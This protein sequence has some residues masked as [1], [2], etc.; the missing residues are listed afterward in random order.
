MTAK[1]IGALGLAQGDCEEGVGKRARRYPRQG[2]RHD[3]RMQPV[4]II[5]VCPEF[6]KTGSMLSRKAAQGLLDNG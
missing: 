4:F 1:A 5:P 6:M 3:D 2:K